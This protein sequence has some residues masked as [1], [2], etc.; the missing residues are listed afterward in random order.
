MKFSTDALVQRAIV[1][2][3]ILHPVSCPET[4]KAVAQLYTEGDERHNQPK[5][6]L[7]VFGDFRKRANSYEVSKVIDRITNEQPRCPHVLN[8]SS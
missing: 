2:W 1:D 4:I 7:P 6:R 8:D 5:H 3:N